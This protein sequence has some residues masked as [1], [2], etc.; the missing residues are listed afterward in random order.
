MSV[1]R[2]QFI[3]IILAAIEI[4]ER[5]NLEAQGCEQAPVK[6]RISEAKAVHLDGNLP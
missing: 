1:M 5:W 6:P 2:S 4:D 3:H